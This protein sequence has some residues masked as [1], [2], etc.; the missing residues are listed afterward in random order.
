MIRWM[1]EFKNLKTHYDSQ[2]ILNNQMVMQL[3]E[4]DRKIKDLLNHNSILINSNKNYEE[5][6]KSI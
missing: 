6:W 1:N 2:R 3:E 5:K 4:L